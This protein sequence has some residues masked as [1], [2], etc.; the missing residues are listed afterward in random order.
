[1]DARYLHLSYVWGV[2]DLLPPEEA[3]QVVLDAVAVMTGLG[4]TYLWCDKYC[5]EQNDDAIKMKQVRNMGFIYENTY[6]TVVAAV[7]VN[8]RYRL[9]GISKARTVPRFVELPDGIRR[10]DL[11]PYASSAEDRA[12]VKR[13]W[14]HQKQLCSQRLLIFSKREVHFECRQ[15]RCRESM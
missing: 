9:C 1:M 6:A 2:P 4:K 3:P 10:V 8:E 7:A 11:N 14:C 13:G 15:M 12:W 5:V